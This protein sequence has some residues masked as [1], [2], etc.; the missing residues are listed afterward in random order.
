MKLSLW[1]ESFPGVYHHGGVYQVFVFRISNNVIHKIYFALVSLLREQV[2][3]SYFNLLCF[4]K[5]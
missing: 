5:L 3:Q 4:R 1:Y 2:Y